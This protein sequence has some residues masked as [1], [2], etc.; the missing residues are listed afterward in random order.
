MCLSVFGDLNRCRPFRI[1]FDSELLLF[2]SYVSSHS[3]ECFIEFIFGR[4]KCHGDQE[5]NCEH[6]LERCKEKEYDYH[7]EIQR[8]SVTAKVFRLKK[9]TSGFILGGM[10][11]MPLLIS[12]MIASTWLWLYEGSIECS[13]A[14]SII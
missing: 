10:F 14:S 8:P 5:V 7:E 2:K 3:P 4:S 12:S 6:D 13:S 1:L 9:R 11:A